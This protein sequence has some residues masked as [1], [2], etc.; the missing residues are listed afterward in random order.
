MPKSLYRLGSFAHKSMTLDVVRTV[1]DTTGRLAPLI[2]R[3][4]AA[5]A[6][7][8]L[9]VPEAELPADVFLAKTSDQRSRPRKP[10]VW[11]LLEASSEV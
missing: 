9:N 2:R 1:Y 8:S 5:Y 3:S 7:L 11:R 10:E 6:R 4:G